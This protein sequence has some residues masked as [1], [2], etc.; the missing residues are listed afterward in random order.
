MSARPVR[1]RGASRE[2]GTGPQ[3]ARDLPERPPGR[4]HGGARARAPLGRRQSRQH[5][6]GGAGGASGGDRER[7]PPARSPDARPRHRG[8]SPQGGGGLAGREARPPEAQRPAA[9]LLAA[10]PAGRARGTVAGGGGEAL[11]LAVAAGGRGR[12]SHALRR[13]LR[14]ADRA[15]PAPA[16]NPWPPAPSSGPRGARRPARLSGGGP[17]REERGPSSRRRRLLAL[18]PA[19][20]AGR[21]LQAA[22]G[23]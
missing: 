20:L 17:A 15:G 9:R 13:R 12:G 16:A 14:P 2:P 21:G 4:R 10:E 18:A 19:G 11:A 5:L 6:W 1:D 3:A 23:G 7:P 22:G 8:G